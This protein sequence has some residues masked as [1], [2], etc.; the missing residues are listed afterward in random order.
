MRK[1]FLKIL[2]RYPEES[3]R[4]F[5]QNEFADFIRRESSEVIRKKIIDKERYIVKSS[6]GQ[7]NWADVPWIGIFDRTITSSAQD[8]FYIVYLFRSDMQG[9]FLSLNQGVTS[10]KEKYGSRVG[11]ALKRNASNFYGMLNPS[12]KGL[13]EG[14]INLEASTILSKLYEK[15][16][17]ISKYYDSGNLPEDSDLE[18]DLVYFVELYLDL[19]RRNAIR[20][21]KE[22]KEDDEVG[23]GIED[24][25]NLRE[26]KRIERNQSLAKSV[27]KKHGYTCKA[28]GFNFYEVYGE[29]GK[30]FIEAHHLTPISMLKGQRVFLNPKTDFTVLC[31][32]CHRMIHKTDVVDKVEEFRIRY[33]TQKN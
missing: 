17:I 1:T 11:D 21:N 13:I 12:T 3:Q 23:L 2:E 25:T 9:L 14:Q 32:N 24:F 26:H 16:A 22:E 4:V 18:K 6:P 5:K 15:G 7:G 28:C 29:I 20:T 31:S 30:E 8:G 27:K 19:T 10:I 33:L